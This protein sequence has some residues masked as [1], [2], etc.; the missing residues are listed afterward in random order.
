ML[1]RVPGVKRVTNKEGNEERE[2]KKTLF[3]APLVLFYPCSTTF[4]T[5]LCINRYTVGSEIYPN[6]R[7][8][9]LH[10]YT[11]SLKKYMKTT[12]AK[13]KKRA[14]SRVPRRPRPFNFCLS[15]PGMH[16]Q[17]NIHM[18]TYIYIYRCMYRDFREGTVHL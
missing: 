14:I 8:R 7:H 16:S 9:P 6:I 18:Y 5:E 10:L 15:H 3:R 1:F 17:P 2:K 11:S 4:H 13:M 12:D